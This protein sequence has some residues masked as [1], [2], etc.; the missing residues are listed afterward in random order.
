MAGSTNL[1]CDRIEIVLADDHTMI[2]GGLRRVLDAEPDLHVVAEARDVE[3]A[4]TATRDHRPQVVVLDLNMPGAPTLPA[5]PKFLEAAQGCAV[6]VLTAEAEPS[7][8]HAAL[9]AGARGYLLKEGA[10]EDLVGAVHAVASGRTYVDP[11]L[12]ARLASTPQDAAAGFPGLTHGD[13]ELAVGTT[14]AGYRI[15]AFVG[16]GG[17]GLVFRATDRALDRPV[18]LKLIAPELASSPIFRARFERESRLAAAIDHPHVVQVFHAAEENGLLYLTMRYV[19]GTDLAKMLRDEHQF[20]PSRA[21]SIVAQVAGA[22]DEAHGLGLVHRDVKPA[23]VL[24]ADRSGREA[25]FLTDFGITRRADD[26]PLTRTGAAMGSVDYMAPEQAHGGEVDART[27]VYALGCVLFEMLTGRVVF[28]RDNE[29]EKL[30][31]H[32][33]DPPPRLRF[34]TADMPGG[35]EDAIDRALAKN[36]DRRQQS[37]GELARAAMHALEV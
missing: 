23:N 17:M 26:E 2:R 20:E 13:P 4:L 30:W 24:I 11:A 14:F 3:Q 7:F 33:H 36:P 5:I 12:G 6:V 31:A 29:L 32:V 16:R 8:A 9:N 19:D 1:S 15:D 34:F 22:L 37:A 25:A 35:L 18:A 27:D 10:E 21:V 28:E